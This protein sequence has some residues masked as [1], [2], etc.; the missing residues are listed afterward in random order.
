MMVGDH[1]ML[2]NMTVDNEIAAI[3]LRGN[4]YPI[5]F[6]LSGELRP[7]SHTALHYSMAC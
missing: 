3:N 1:V 4:V 7:V 5:V 6:S 2:A